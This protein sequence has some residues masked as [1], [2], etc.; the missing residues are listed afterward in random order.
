MTMSTSSVD[1]QIGATRNV[2]NQFC[3]RGMII[4]LVWNREDETFSWIVMIPV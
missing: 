1:C 4:S 3:H 2:V